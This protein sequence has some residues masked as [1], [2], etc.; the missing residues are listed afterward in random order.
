MSLSVSKETVLF[1]WRA[2]I[3]Q[4]LEVPSSSVYAQISVAVV[5]TVITVSIFNFSIGSYTSDFCLWEREPLV[6]PRV[7]P[8]HAPQFLPA[9]PAVRK[10]SATRLEDSQVS[11]TIELVCII[12]FT[13]EYLLRLLTCTTDPEMTVLRFVLEPLNILDLVA[14]LPWYI[15]EIMST[16]MEGDNSDL[17][18]ALGA[19]RIMRLF[20]VF[21]VFKM[22]K[23]MK[24][25]LVL[26]RP[27]QRSV[28]ILFLLLISVLIM[29]RSPANCS[30]PPRRSRR[31]IQRTGARWCCS[32]T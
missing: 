8:W 10:C 6:G 9:E 19:V 13:A 21:R 14:V 15:I 12:V 4:T 20:R 17:Q 3:W 2:W 7:G 29:V 5:M 23:E 27:L 28:T 26:M 30:S 22:S 11:K 18:K 25:M 1:R 31:C 16:T 24:M 32:L